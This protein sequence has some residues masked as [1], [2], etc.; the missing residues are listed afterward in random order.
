MSACTKKAATLGGVQPD[1]QILEG[2]DSDHDGVR[3]DVQQWIQARYPN[4]HDS[5]RIS[6]KMRVEQDFIYCFN[7]VPGDVR[8]RAETFLNRSKQHEFSFRVW[9][10]GL[11]S[12]VEPIILKI[13]ASNSN[14]QWDIGVIHTKANIGK[15]P[16]DIQV[17]IYPK[18]KLISKQGRS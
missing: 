14:Q 2:A 4:G 12:S 11:K 1:Q 6:P 17:E 3:D 7:L 15:E 9:P 10:G 13:N 8:I 16:L 5:W 18:P